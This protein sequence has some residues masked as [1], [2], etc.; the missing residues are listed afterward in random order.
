VSLEKL[1]IEEI[2]KYI[3]DDPVRP[4]LSA[5]FR[6]S[7]N[8][9]V[10]ALYEDQYAKHAP[11]LHEGPRAIVCVAYTNEIPIT[12]M[13]LGLMS[14]SASQDGQRG[15]IAV[16]YTVWSYDRGAGREIV[17]SVAS[18]VKQEYNV[19]RWITLSPL[20]EMAERFHI[21][22]GASLLERGNECQNFEYV[23]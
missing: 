21:K 6:S 3:N 22:N 5:D 13:E 1:N 10:Y 12:E 17:L 9:E 11:V 16:F 15:N 19:D 23:V 4:H 7:V 8:R 2:N 14:R 18:H 20:T